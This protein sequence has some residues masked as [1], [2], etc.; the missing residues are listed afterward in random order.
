MLRR[1]KICDASPSTTWGTG[2]RLSQQPTQ[3]TFGA[4][5]RRKPAELKEVSDNIG[6]LELER[7]IMEICLVRGDVDN[8]TDSEVRGIAKY[9]ADFKPGSIRVTTLAKPDTELKTKAVTKTALEKA[10]AQIAEKSGIEVEI[11]API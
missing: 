1:T 8:S 3:K 7:W 6:R 2:T 10:A 9:A 11:T 5:T 4:L